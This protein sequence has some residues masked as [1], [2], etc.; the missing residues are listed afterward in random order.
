MAKKRTELAKPRAPKTD[1]KQTRAALAQAA[2]KHFPKIKRAAERALRTVGLP[3]LQVHGMTF[4]V[5][6]R[7][8]LDQCSPPCDPEKESCKLSSTG[9]WMCVPDR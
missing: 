7:S 2:T 4:S 6:E 3:N 9:V 1:A 8:V 5:D